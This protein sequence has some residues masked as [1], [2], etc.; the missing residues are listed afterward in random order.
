M[1]YLL[2]VDAALAA[3]GA[4]MTV[5]ISY[6]CL[7]FGIYRNTSSEIHQ[8]LPGLLIVS[9]CFLILAL[10]AGAA[11]YGLVKRRAWHWPAQALLA[12]LLPV[13][14]LVVYA[15]LKSA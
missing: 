9:A 2:Y 14:Y 4:A 13:L 3:L 5:A 6:V 7:V 8:G 1:K 12:V 15:N 11:T 10:V